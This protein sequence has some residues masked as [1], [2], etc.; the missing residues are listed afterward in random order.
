MEYLSRELNVRAGNVKAQLR[1]QYY[2]AESKNRVFIYRLGQ[3]VASLEHHFHEVEEKLSKLQS[4]GDLEARLTRGTQELR[5][6]E[7]AVNLVELNTL[8]PDDIEANL[9]HSQKLYELLSEL[10]SE[11]EGS[12]KEGRRQ[13][14]DSPELTP[15][16]DAIKEMYNRL[17]GEVTLRKTR[18]EAAAKLARSVEKGLDSLDAWA[19]SVN[20]HI[21]SNVDNAQ[22][23]QVLMIFFFGLSCGY[24]AGITSL[25]QS[26]KFF[27]VIIGS[28]H[29]TYDLIGRYYTLQFSAIAFSIVIRLVGL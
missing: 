11:V 2:P 1:T 19:Q 16:V 26:V 23:L 21:N 27:S 18:L 12:I 20:D 25:F 9:K 17:G 5:R 8:L 10:K 24:L 3:Q 29:V 6:V 14:V 22:V 28:F 13:A 15:K 7:E 4:S